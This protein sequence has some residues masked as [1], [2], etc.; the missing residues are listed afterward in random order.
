MISRK[1][2]SRQVTATQVPRWQLICAILFL[3][4]SLVTT[5]T[6]QK[7]Q[8][9]LPQ[10]YIDTTWN[11]PTGGTTWAAHTSAQLSS[12][13]TSAVPGDLIVLDAGTVYSGYFMLPAKSNPNKK[14]IYIESS[15]YASLPAPGT[16]VSPANAANMP[17]IVTPGATN[18]VR[19]QD[20]A[21]YWRFVGVEI[22]S[23]SNY[24]P[25]GYTP[26]I[27]F[28]YALV[29][30]YNYP[31]TSNIPDH[32]F[33]DRCYLHGDATHDLQEGISANF[34][35]FALVDSYISEIHAKSID[36]QA[37]VSYVTPGPIKLVNNHLEAAGENVMF[38]GSGNGAFGF[39]PSDIEVRNNYLYKPLSWV[40]LSLNGTYSVKNAFELKSA[41]RVLFD[42]NTIANVWA[43][44]QNGAAFLLTVRSSQ[45][46]D[47]AVVE[48]V[49]VT[50]NVLRNVVMGFNTLAADSQCGTSSYPNC[51][52]A[53]ATGRWNISDNQVTLFD[54]TAQ[55]A[56]GAHTGLI[57]FSPGIDNPNGG[58]VIGLHDV[59][60]QHNSVI[61]YRSQ[62]CWTSAYFAV[63]GSWRLPFPQPLTK[64]IWVLDNALCNE[65]TGD[66][67]Q[68]GTTGLAEYMGS[69]STPPYDVT[70]RFYGNV[71]F[72]P[73]NNR[74]YTFPA[75]NYATTVAFTYVNPSAN[76]YQLLTPYWTDTSDGQLGGIN[77]ASLPA[78]TGP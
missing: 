43:A 1:N 27:N 60:V 6:A 48:D 65:P 24:K 45:S 77:F 5:A 66:W 61:P 40:P 17:K 23:N 9:V 67:G 7:P 47:I 4:A 10:V 41:Q 33:F 64:N 25:A 62:I 44:G 42:S 19:L 37:V 18:A 21:N 8:A 53:G 59:V 39:V 14:W 72:V 34:T 12:A 28:G 71:M 52:N 2:A 46:G 3:T 63:P 75:H 51:H 57:V 38:G 32:I 69:P 29:D 16:R 50:N 11:R 22:Y 13:L 55:G 78:S 74:V 36:T 49:T 76:D 54:T 26:G 58:A 35:N 30:K 20:G 31:G 70:Q 73:S 68:Q 15:A 56:I